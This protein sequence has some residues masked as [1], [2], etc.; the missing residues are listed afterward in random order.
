MTDKMPYETGENS[1]HLQGEKKEKKEID[2]SGLSWFETFCAMEAE[3]LA[4]KEKE[5]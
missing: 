1:Y 2:Y 3:K 5:E 4:E